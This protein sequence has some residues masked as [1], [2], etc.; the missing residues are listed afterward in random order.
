[1]Y[2]IKTENDEV[3]KRS[4]KE[5]IEKLEKVN[6]IQI[7]NKLFNI[8]F[9]LGSDYKMLRLLY[10]QKAANALKGCVWC[11]CSMGDIPKKRIFGQ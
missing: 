3:L 10:G 9:Y 11:K 7:E 4:L 2:E 6:T 8:E 1:M 5:L